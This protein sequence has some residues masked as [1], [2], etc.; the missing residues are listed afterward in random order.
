MKDGSSV[1]HRYNSCVFIFLFGGPS[2]IDLW[3]MKPAAPAEI[4]GD[5]KP[6]STKVPGIQ[7]CEHLPGLA[8][9][10]DKVCLVRSMTHNMNVHGP[11]CSEI[12]SGREYFNAPTT[13][14]ADP[15]DWPSLS[16][17]M[18]R[19]GQPH[20]GVPP[21]IVL[22]WYLQFTGQSRRIASQTGGRMGERHNALTV[23]RWSARVS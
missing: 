3:D 22:P 16:S 18:M 8:S 5:F 17:M 7:I 19:F 4:R 13:D 12:F 11:A 2:Q 1:K 21:S 10:M 20:G 15:Q 9:Q 6:V 23:G 14:Q